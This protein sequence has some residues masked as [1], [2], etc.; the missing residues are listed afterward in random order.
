MNHDR[1]IKKTDGQSSPWVWLTLCPPR[2]ALLPD[3]SLP[4]GSPRW[5]LTCGWLFPQCVCAHIC[6]CVR[7]FI[8]RQHLQK[9]A[10]A[11]TF[12]L[13]F[14]GFGQW[15]V[16]VCKGVQAGKVRA[17]TVRSHHNLE[18]ALLGSCWRTRGE[19]HRGGGDMM[20]D[21]EGHRGRSAH[22]SAGGI[23]RSNRTVTTCLC[24]LLEC[25]CRCTCVFALTRVIFFPPAVVA[26]VWSPL[27]M[28]EMFCLQALIIQPSVWNKFAFR[29]RSLLWYM[30]YTPSHAHSIRSC[31]LFLSHSGVFEETRCRSRFPH[32]FLLHV[33]TFLLSFW[34]TS[35]TMDWLGAWITQRERVFELVSPC[36]IK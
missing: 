3:K 23:Y 18:H 4:R 34:T 15:E 10:W 36:Q 16:C 19:G 5:A 6:V 25:A 8:R 24:H 13:Q 31:L 27:A 12:R 26:D 2:G 11:E 17:P 29:R 9:G 20:D 22:S 28:R 35:S 1:A 21:R 32:R 14:I 7:L 30:P 33:T